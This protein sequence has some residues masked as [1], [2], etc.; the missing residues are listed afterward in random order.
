MSRNIFVDADSATWYSTNTC[1]ELKI[2]TFE[3][4]PVPNMDSAQI[5]DLLMKK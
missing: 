5:G 1:S 2:F 3:N 4:V